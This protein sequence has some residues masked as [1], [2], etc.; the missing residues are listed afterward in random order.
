MLKAL[1]ALETFT[2]L[3]WLFGYVEKRFE[4]KAKVD[5][6]I[7]M[8]SKTRQQ[9]IT[10]HILLNISRGIGNRWSVIRI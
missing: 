10:I 1:V 3:S 6:N 5:F 9:I 7:Y 4:K 2:F 8:T